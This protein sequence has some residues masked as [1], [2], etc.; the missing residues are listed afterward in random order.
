MASPAIAG[1][2]VVV[3]VDVGIGPAAYWFSG[4]LFEN[5]G[6]LPHFGIQINVQAIIDKDLIEAN[7]NRVPDKYRGMAA[8][9]TELRVSPSFLIPSA[10][11]ISPKLDALGGVGMYGATWTPIGLTLISTGQK[12][13]RD[14]NPSRGRFSLDADLLLTALFIHSDFPAIPMTFFFRP[15]VQLKMTLL[16]SVT[17][18]F[19]IS[20]G[21]GAQAYIPQRL[22]SFFE[23][24][25]FEEDVWFAGFAFLKF[26]V[27]FPYEVAL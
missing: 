23:V 2:G 26:H 15:G 11:I 19:L 6:W 20:L 4:R 21:G 17:K 14:W 27:R 25:P 13:A 1:N 22:G 9:I 24:T 12:S 10:L 8:S 3:P 16:L 7:W 18:T 5:R